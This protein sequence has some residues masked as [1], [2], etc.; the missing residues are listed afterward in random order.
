LQGGSNGGGH[1]AAVAYVDGKVNA[2]TDESNKVLTAYVNV[3][4]GQ[5]Q[6]WCKLAK[7]VNLIIKMLMSLTDNKNMLTIM[8]V[9]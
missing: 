3:R 5:G 8:M 9:M 2:D 7:G 6:E 4:V 1:A